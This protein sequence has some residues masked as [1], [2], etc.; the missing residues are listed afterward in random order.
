MGQDEPIPVAGLHAAVEM[1]SIASVG[2]G[3]L[4]QVVPP[5]LPNPTLPYPNPNPT[6]TPP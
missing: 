2:S 3:W 4:R 5:T 6:L 1:A